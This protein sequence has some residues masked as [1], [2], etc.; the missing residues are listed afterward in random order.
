MKR[1]TSTV[2]PFIKQISR[3]RS[4]SLKI[5]VPE[6]MEV[7]HDLFDGY[8]KNGGPADAVKLLCDAK[9]IRM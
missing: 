2:M 9:M 5:A 4:A 6:S 7:D 8:C 3:L 1:S